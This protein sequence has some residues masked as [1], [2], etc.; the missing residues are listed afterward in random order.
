ME[1]NSRRI[2]MFCAVLVLIGMLVISTSALAKGPDGANQAA[3]QTRSQIAASTQAQA[4]VQVRSQAG[5]GC[6]ASCDGSQEHNGQYSRSGQT[7]GPGDGTGPIGGGQ[8]GPGP[9]G[10]CLDVDNDGICDCQE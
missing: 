9:Y 5:P 6:T 4:Q 7:Y 3:T 1:R 2:I 10:K 8:F